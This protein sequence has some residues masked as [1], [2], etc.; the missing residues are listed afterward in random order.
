MLRTCSW[1]LLPVLLT[2]NGEVAA[3]PVCATTI[4][5][6]ESLLDEPALPQTWAETTMDDGKPLVLS[7]VES[8]GSLLL[9]FTKTGEG[10]WAESSGAICRSGSVFEARFSGKQIRIGPAAGWIL[11]SS[12][13]NGGKFTLTKLDSDQLRIATSGWS[14]EFS[15]VTE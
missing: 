2:L 13:K 8:N 6:L 10:L 11:R 7:I 12:L 4:S 15:P 1:F 3:S 9:G 5:E 14:G